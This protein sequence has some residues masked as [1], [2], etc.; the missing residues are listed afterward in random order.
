M[1][2]VIGLCVDMA[3]RLRFGYCIGVVIVMCSWLGFLSLRDWSINQMD[4]CEIP[5]TSKG[6]L[7]WPL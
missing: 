7:E 1:V 5:D 6:L 3:I 4:D 2:N